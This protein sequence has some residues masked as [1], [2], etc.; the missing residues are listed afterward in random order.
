M[1]GFEIISHLQAGLKVE[2]L[3][4]MAIANNVANLNTPNYRRMQVDFK[5]LINNIVS[6][7]RDVDPNKLDF[8][9]YN[10]KNTPVKA[11]GNDVSLD[12]EVVDMVKNNL[13]HE[14]YMRTLKKKYT[15][16]DLAMKTTG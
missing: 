7:N 3:K 9:F 2:G 1:K 16:I 14:T 11:N 10:P 6:E 8:E 13:K 12:R 4:Q 15:Q 5:D